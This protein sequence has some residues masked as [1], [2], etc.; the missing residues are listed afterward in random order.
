MRLFAD[1]VTLLLPSSIQPIIVLFYIISVL[2]C[3][4]IQRRSLTK[5]NKST[6]IISGAGIGIGRGIAEAFAQDGYRVIA[7][8]VLVDEGTAV[9][10]VCKAPGRTL[11]FMK[12][13]LPILTR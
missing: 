3:S 9:V 4:T 10:S 12:W 2:V 13:T 6:V 8:D 11:N 7:T 1:T 5:V